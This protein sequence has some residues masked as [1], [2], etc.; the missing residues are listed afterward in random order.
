MKTHTLRWIGIGFLAFV[1][2]IL[3]ALRLY[4]STWL[5]NYVNNVLGHIDGYQGSVE[6]I[7][8]DLYR[9]AYRINKLALNKVNGH[10][11]TPF[12]A[13]DKTDFS[14]QWSSLLHGRVVS[15]V[16]LTHPVI[17]FAV[18]NSQKQTG[19]NVDWTKPIKDLM[20]IDINYVKFEDGAITYQDFSST[21][22]VNI[23]IH[24]M[25]GKVTNL[26]NVKDPNNEL[27]SS[28]TVNGTSI[29]NGTLKI[30]GRLNILKDIPDM[31]LLLALEKVNLPA[32]NSYSEAYGAFDFASG[33]FSLYSQMIVKDSQVHGYIKPIV[34]HLSV[35]VLKKANPLEIVWSSAVAAVLKVFTN[36]S[37]DQFATK[38]D[39]DGTVGNINT[40]TWSTL[41][42]IFRN[43]FINAMSKG[44]DQT[45]QEGIVQP[46]PQ[47]Q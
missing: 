34:T 23:Y 28:L 4:L 19:E 3:I 5:L 47:Q 2:I 27:P 31:N 37:Q 35:D 41:G 29:G 44:F 39:L 33:D 43:A 25:N 11:P 10:I 17:N 13:I 20:P 46:Q 45:G 24:Q 26:R 15:S 21:P 7:N 36:P 22:Q 42:G 1:L 32:L 14:L 6:S 12:I 30:N 16:D 8:I 9:G 40:D 18:N 38:I